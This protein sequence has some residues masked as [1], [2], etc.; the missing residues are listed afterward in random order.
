MEY[1][2]LSP[3]RWVIL[4]L[5][6]IIMWGFYWYIGFNQTIVKYIL[7][8]T[9]VILLAF[10]LNDVFKSFSKKGSYDK[11]IAIIISLI[12]LSFLVTF[13]YW[14]Q[15]PI[16]TFRA[17]ASQFLILYYY[18]LKH[19]NV[20]FGNLNRLITVFAGIYIVL[21]LI[22]LAA[23]PRVLFGNLEEIGDERGFF[24]ILQ[25]NGI[26][27]LC[28][29]Y[30]ICLMNMCKK[31]GKKSFWVIAAIVSYVVVFLSLSR[32]LILSIS[33]VTLVFLFIYNKKIL[34][35]ATIIMALGGYSLLS[36][37]EIV[38]SLYTMTHDQIEERSEGNLRLV[39]YTQFTEHFP[40]HV[41]TMLFGNGEPHVASSYGQREEQLKSSYGFNRSDAGY[42]HII[43]SY[44]LV[45]LLVFISLLFKVIK[46][47]VSFDSKGY[48]LFVYFLFIVN[49]L[50]STFFSY[51]AS[52]VIC[53]Y[54]LELERQSTARCGVSVTQ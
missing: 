32:N 51:S 5:V 42:V 9:A 49:V 26:D 25:L 36:Q 21:W 35:G 7:F 47:R 44:G 27:T 41:G 20:G 16:L 46:Q 39:E 11:Y 18:L 33:L 13:V 37:N 31:G 30:F 1:R 29:F 43:T 4:L 34:V 22:A 2:K 50:A 40:F 52:L 38:D 12:L 10:S 24:R 8:I 14:G 54:A 17:A 23:A 19:F 48:K 53:L 28:L 6:P 3:I 45:M 15:N